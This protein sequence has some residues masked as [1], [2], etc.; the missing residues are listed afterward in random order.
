MHSKLGRL[1]AFRTIGFNE[2]SNILK[3]LSRPLSGYLGGSEFSDGHFIR[4]LEWDW[5]SAFGVIN[6]IPC[7]SATSGLLA[8]CVA[9]GIDRHSVVWTTPYTMSATAACAVLLGARVRFIDIEPVRYSMDIDKFP[10]DELPHAIIVTNL[11]GH[12]AYLS[13]LRRWCDSNAVI[14]IEDN[15]QSPFAMENREYTGTIGHMGVFSLNVHKHI[16]AGEGGIVVTDIPEYAR[17]IRNFINHGELAGGRA[18]LNLRMTEPTAAVACAQLKRA[19]KIIYERCELAN[20]LSDIFSQIPWIKPSVEDK[21]CKHVYYLWT[22]RV[23]E[24]R[25]APLVEFMNSR[26]V[27][28]RAG[29][30]VNLC[31]IF[32]PSQDTPVAREIDRSLV[33]FEVCAYSPTSTQIKTMY[34]IATQARDYL[35]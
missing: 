13:K 26:G 24:N 11:F 19:P 30:S 10:E 16:Q 20:N 12:P 4:K 23:P 18:G 29:Y 22:A 17:R 14:M 32:D 2:K 25:Q 28:L 34:R 1:P 5:A 35:S 3:S 27:P 21:G 6:A 9:V 15:A 31:D 8:A 7:N 33:S